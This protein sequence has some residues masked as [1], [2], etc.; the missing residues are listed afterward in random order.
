MLIIEIIDT[1]SV[2]KFIQF[3]NVS[4]GQAGMPRTKSIDLIFVISFELAGGKI[5][6]AIMTFYLTEYKSSNIQIA[7]AIDA[8]HWE[9]KPS[10]RD[11]AKCFEHI[12]SFS[13]Y[14]ANTCFLCSMRMYD[15]TNL[16]HAYQFKY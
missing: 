11:V 1:Y 13:L 15:R 5:P 12:K 2:L 4:E 14:N 6:S 7:L 9:K 8:S 3:K 16:K 10:L